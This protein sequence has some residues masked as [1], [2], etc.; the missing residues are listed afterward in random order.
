MENKE[1]GDENQKSG[2]GG[3]PIARRRGKRIE[4]EVLDE[5]QAA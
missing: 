3:G 1:Q 2:G 4:P 5:A